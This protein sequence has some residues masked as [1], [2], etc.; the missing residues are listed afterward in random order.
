MTGEAGR[1][2]EAGVATGSPETPH[3][4]E[5]SPPV[6]DLSEIYSILPDDHR[7]P[8][9]MRQLLEC[10]LDGEGLLEFQPGH[11]A[12]MICGTGF[13]AGMPVGIIAIR[14]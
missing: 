10:I 2:G 9:D 6:R 7:Q 8:Y 4:T 13:I 11:A 5:I 14:K 3:A 12:E 1:A